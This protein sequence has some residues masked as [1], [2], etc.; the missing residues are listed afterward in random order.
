MTLLG[1]FGDCGLNDFAQFEV[2]V[3]ETWS[4]EFSTFFG[5]EAMMIP[6]S[7]ELS[8]LVDFVGFSK[9]SMIFKRSSEANV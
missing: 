3:M 8:S 6:R 1:E 4:F 7:V 5:V 2:Q 9:F